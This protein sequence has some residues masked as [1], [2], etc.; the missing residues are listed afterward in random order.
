MLVRQSAI[1]GQEC[2]SYVFPFCSE[3]CERVLSSRLLHAVEVSVTLI[4]DKPGPWLIGK[5]APTNAI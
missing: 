5:P 2:P 4:L 1:D 3:T